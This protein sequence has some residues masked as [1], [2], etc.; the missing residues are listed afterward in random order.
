MR[1]LDGITDSVDVNSGELSRQPRAG[2]LGVLQS[3]KLLRVG[4]LQQQM[5]ISPKHR[6]RALC[7]PSVIHILYP[8]MESTINR[9]LNNLEMYKKTEDVN[10]IVFKRPLSFIRPCATSTVSHSKLNPL[11]CHL[12]R[13]ASN[14]LLSKCSFGKEDTG[15]V[16]QAQILCSE[17]VKWRFLKSGNFFLQIQ[18]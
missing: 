18:F 4:H 5:D 6:R 2:G 13:L 7:A 10:L 1:W 12:P 3:V 14:S 16:S 9:Q 11:V 17:E 8:K 15:E